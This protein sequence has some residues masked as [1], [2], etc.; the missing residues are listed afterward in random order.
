VLKTEVKAVLPEIFAKASIYLQPWG[1]WD[2]ENA[3]N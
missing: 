3:G 2:V 1:S